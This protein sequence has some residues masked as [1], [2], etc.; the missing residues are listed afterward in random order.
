[1]MVTRQMNAI[2][3]WVENLT[4]R[5]ANLTRIKGTVLRRNRPRHISE[6]REVM[7]TGRMMSTEYQSGQ[8]GITNKQSRTPHNRDLEID[9][10]EPK[11]GTSVIPEMALE[12][13]LWWIP[14]YPREKAENMEEIRDFW[15]SP[16]RLQNRHLTDDRVRSPYP[17]RS[18]R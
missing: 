13:C 17:F 8:F 11:T 9:D 18:I 5:Q 2:K 16:D 1:M 3:T 12:Q 4:Q 10:S 7:P 14:K 15:M 6:Q